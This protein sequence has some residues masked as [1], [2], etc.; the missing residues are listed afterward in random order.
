MSSLLEDRTEYGPKTLTFDSQIFDDLRSISDD[1]IT[2]E[3]PKYSIVLDSGYVPVEVDGARHRINTSV[4]DLG[5]TMSKGQEQLDGENAGQFKREIDM[6]FAEFREQTASSS[7]ALMGSLESNQNRQPEITGRIDT[8]M[9]TTTMLLEKIDS[10]EGPE[11]AMRS[12]YE[13]ILLAQGTLHQQSFDLEAARHAGGILCGASGQT[14]SLLSSKIVQFDSE[15]GHT[16]AGNQM[17][18]EAA[19]SSALTLKNLQ[20]IA[21]NLTHGASSLLDK[22]TETT[23]RFGGLMSQ[24]DDMIVQMKRG[25]A[26]SKDVEQFCGLLRSNLE[27]YRQQNGKLST[28]LIESM[29]EM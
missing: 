17:E 16:D 22:N 23:Q 1:D 15:P 29:H 28:A 4:S 18:R 24:L 9:R 10:K 27:E 19:V 21:D 13:S 20:G 26:N 5:T 11:M 14:L 2:S 12:L 8:L 25:Y 3:V 6:L 7:S